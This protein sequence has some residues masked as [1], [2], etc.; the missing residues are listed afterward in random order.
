MLNAELEKIFM[1]L[2]ALHS[3]STSSVTCDSCQA[4]TVACIMNV[5]DFIEEMGLASCA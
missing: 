5:G 1:Q 4:R 3:S 2:T